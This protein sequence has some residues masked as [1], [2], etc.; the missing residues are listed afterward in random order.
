MITLIARF[1]VYSMV[2][3]GFYQSAT[4]IPAASRMATA[5]VWPVAVGSIIAANL[6][7]AAAE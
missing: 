2:A 4:S 7:A 6:P 1:V 5:I 3:A